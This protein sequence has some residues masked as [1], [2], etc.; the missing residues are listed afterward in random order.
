MDA[1]R[2]RLQLPENDPPEDRLSQTK[3][4]QIQALVGEPDRLL[5]LGGEHADTV[6]DGVGTAQACLVF[7]RLS[8]PPNRNFKLRWNI[9]PLNLYISIL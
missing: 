5:A 9:L 8:N 7:E 4:D 3:T 2:T 6:A 1:D